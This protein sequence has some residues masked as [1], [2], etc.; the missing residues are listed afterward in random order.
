MIHQTIAAAL[1]SRL[2]LLNLPTQYE[3]SAFTPVAGVVYLSEAILPST[4]LAVGLANTAADEYSGIYQVTVHA[5]KGGSKGPGMA[6]AKSIQDQFQRGLELVRDGIKVT[7]LRCSQAPALTD[8]DR[9]LIPVSVDY[10][11]LT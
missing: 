7:V 5:P 8:G 2:S 4:T 9:W 3:N 10:R 11:A 6:A 1:A